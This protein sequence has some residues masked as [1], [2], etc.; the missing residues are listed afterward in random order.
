MFGVFGV[1]SKTVHTHQQQN[2]SL[3]RSKCRRRRVCPPEFKLFRSH[4][5][6]YAGLRWDSWERCTDTD[7]TS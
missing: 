5:L 2:R 1:K 7:T 4:F 6:M 3:D